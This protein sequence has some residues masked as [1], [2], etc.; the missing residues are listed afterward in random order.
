I[1][2]ACHR[3]LELRHGI[4]LLGGGLKPFVSFCKVCG[5]ALAVGVHQA[6]AVLGHPVALLCCLVKP[7][8][9]FTIVTGYSS[10]FSMH[11]R[12]TILGSGFPLRG[13]RSIPLDRFRQV[14]SSS[15]TCSVVIS[16]SRLGRSV[17]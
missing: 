1:F 14:D 17:S 4:A 16:Q 5:N 8:R 13:R 7:L 15:L 9:G 6:K 10:A 11:G 2:S 12:Q 3:Q